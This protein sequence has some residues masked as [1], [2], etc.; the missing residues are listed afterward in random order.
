MRIG[1]PP[2]LLPASQALLLQVGILR[3]H[4]LHHVLRLV[5]FSGLVMR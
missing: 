2:G 5:A 4:L 3:E 1:L